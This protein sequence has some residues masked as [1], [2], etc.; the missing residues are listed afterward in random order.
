LVAIEFYDE[1][2]PWRYSPDVLDPAT[3]RLRPWLALVVLT[4]E[5]F[6]DQGVVPGRPL[7]FIEVKDLATLPPPDQLGAWAHVHSNRRV[8]A[9]IG[10]CEYLG[11]LLKP[12]GVD[13]RVG[14]RDMDVRVPGS[15]LPG[16]DD[17]AL[18]HV[19]RLGGALKVPDKDLKPDEVTEQTRYENWDQP[20]PH[21]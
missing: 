19:L 1:D 9:S 3:G 11:R 20:F 2:F 12:R 4:E 21:P 16:V 6:A 7:P 5:E 10:D 8:T 15:G 14:S 13:A 18:R 17:P